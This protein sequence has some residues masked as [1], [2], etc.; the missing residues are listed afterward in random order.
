MI[1][2]YDLENVAIDG[3][4]PSEIIARHPAIAIPLFGV[5]LDVDTG[6]RFEFL[7]K[8]FLSPPSALL[9]GG[10]QLFSAVALDGFHT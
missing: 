3:E 10:G 5:D 8:L 7:K 6:F 9:A 2:E 4:E 1:G